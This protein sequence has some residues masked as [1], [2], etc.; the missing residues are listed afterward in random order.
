MAVA[1][2]AY[3]FFAQLAILV[4]DAPGLDSGLPYLRPLASCDSRGIASWYER[5]GYVH[6]WLT[7]DYEE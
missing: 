4:V 3:F 7:H 5:D 2:C 6:A 1:K